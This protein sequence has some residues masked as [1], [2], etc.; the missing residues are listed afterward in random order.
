MIKAILFGAMVI[1]V[2]LVGIEFSLLSIVKELRAL[3][4]KRS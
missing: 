4:R 2:V 1:S 3:N